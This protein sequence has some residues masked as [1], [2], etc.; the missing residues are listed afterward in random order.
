MT[1]PSINPIA[2]GDKVPDFDLPATDGKGYS[3]ESIA[4]LPLV[5]IFLAN[6]CPYVAAWEDRILAIGKEYGERGV[7]FAAISANDAQRF[8]QD[9]FEEMGKR[10]EEHGYCFPYLY[11]ES[12]SVA[13]TFGATKTPEVF[14]FNPEGNLVYH[15]AVDG[16]F[17][18]GPD[19]EP[20]LRDAL[21]EL[22]VGEEISR[23]TTPPLGCSMKWKG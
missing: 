20:Y 8:P 21:D 7:R 23:P 4:G 22:L 11:D 16:D 2:I 19:T 10:V 6:H 9:S 5:V 1:A 3:L 17:E 14:V 13:R 15:G 12:Q 18:E